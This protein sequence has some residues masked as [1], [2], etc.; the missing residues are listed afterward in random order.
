PRGTK[1]AREAAKFLMFVTNTTNFVEFATRTTIFPGRISVA[2][3]PYFTEPDGTLEGEAR[4]IGARLLPLVDATPLNLPNSQQ[5][6]DAMD[7]AMTLALQGKLSPAEAIAQ[8]AA[9]WEQLIK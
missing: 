3:S 8:A 2:E 1:N 4:L 7:N 6:T 9:E 5:R